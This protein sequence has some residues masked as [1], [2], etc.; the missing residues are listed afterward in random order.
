M[1]YS[2]DKSS[3]PT[4]RR[5]SRITFATECRR[6]LSGS[7]A[8]G[9]LRSCLCRGLPSRILM[10]YMCA[11][12]VEIENR[13]N[14]HT[15][16]PHPA[17]RQP[18]VVCRHVCVILGLI[19]SIAGDSR[20]VWCRHLTFKIMICCSDSSFM[21]TMVQLDE[22][23]EQAGQLQVHSSY[24][25]SSNLQTT[26]LLYLHFLHP[27]HCLVTLP[28]KPIITKNSK[29]LYMA[30]TLRLTYAPTC[31][32]VAQRS[33]AA[34]LSLSILTASSSARGMASVSIASLSNS[35]V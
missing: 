7:V 18:G 34:P 28:T 6:S 16:V 14:W 32:N 29:R 20:V 2:V 5:T 11:L 19:P 3:L 35:F 13:A 33:G 9:A 23:R 27:M 4:T 25:T 26:S 31:M 10:A 8:R 21:P 1:S 24:M 22:G 15:V 12:D 17:L 30:A